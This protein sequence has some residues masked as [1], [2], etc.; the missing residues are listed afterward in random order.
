M[1]PKRHLIL[2]KLDTK[3]G[4]FGRWPQ[5]L[6]H[7]AQKRDHAVVPEDFLRLTEG[8]EERLIEAGDNLEIEH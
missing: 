5:L 3:P 2:P 7:R 8:G 4:R 1:R 6:W